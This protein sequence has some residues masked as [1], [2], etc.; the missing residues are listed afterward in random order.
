VIH[1]YGQ[2]FQIGHRAIEELFD[3]PVTVTEKVDGSQL[4]ML[5]TEAGAL[6][7]RSKN[8]QIILEAPVDKFKLAVEQA[9][10]LSLHPGWVYRCEYLQKPKHNALAYSRVPAHNI[11][12]YD[13]MV[14]S[15]T[16]LS[17]TELQAEAARI[18]LECVPVF[19]DNELVKDPTNG[20]WLGA[21]LERESVL[22][23]TKV[24]GIV[25]KNYERFGQDKKIL[26]GK[27][28]QPD[29]QEVNKANWK[30]ENPRQQDI[31]SRLIFEY[32]TEARWA[33]AVQ[34]LRDAGLLQDKAQDIG[35]L[36]REVPDDVLKEAEA[37]IRDKLWAWAWPQV[38]HGLT[39]GMPEWYKK[40][41]PD[42]T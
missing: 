10:M 2:I 34:H 35:L 31:L 7:L 17:M 27:L 21:F 11:I 20:A 15:E 25:V 4:S 32:A 26:M 23:G 18:G 16:Y 42:V 40:Q 9:R 19:V 12:L 28:V 24:E 36:I 33:K 41:L 5:H 29:F 38:R 14:G 39:R 37:E 6:E 3:G 30:S 8:A 22:G 13:I 1:N